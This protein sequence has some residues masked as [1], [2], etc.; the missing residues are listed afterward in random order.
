MIHKKGASSKVSSTVAERGKV[1]GQ[2]HESHVNIGLAW[3][4]LIQQHYQ[5][6]LPHVIPASLVEL[7]MVQFK[8]NRSCRVYREDNYV[9]LHAYAQFA[10]HSQ[11]KERKHE[12]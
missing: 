4:G 12:A 5:M 7:M 8:A 11:K 3:T 1:Y 6:T 9:D 2:P 10:E